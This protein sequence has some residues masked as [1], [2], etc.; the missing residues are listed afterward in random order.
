MIIAKQKRKEN[1]AEYLLY[2]WQIEDLIRASNF[3]IEQIQK[4][5]I[6]QF[7]QP[8]EVRMQMRDWYQN[9]MA[10]MERENVKEHGH[11]QVLHNLLED[12]N[13]LHI[14]LLRTPSQIQYNSLFFST[15]SYLTELRAKEKASPEVSDVELALNAL[16]G[17]LLLRLQKREIT[18]GTQAAM[19]QIGKWI[20]VLSAKYKENE[21]GSLKLEN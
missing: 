6:N 19:A 9:L 13:D 11:I 7:D 12:V 20:A 18:A 1:I 2:M 4:N 10:M 21:A 17:I 14:A 15:V 8:E 5:I 16:Y 3:D